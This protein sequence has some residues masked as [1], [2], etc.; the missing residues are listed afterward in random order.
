MRDQ[1][2]KST[3]VLSSRPWFWKNNN[4]SGLKIVR[5]KIRGGRNCLNKQKIIEWLIIGKCL[6][7]FCEML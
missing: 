6:R 5:I 3:E 7:L 4:C 1:S 2:F